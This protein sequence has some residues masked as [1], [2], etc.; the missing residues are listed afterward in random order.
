M[1]NIQQYIDLLKVE[2]EKASESL[3][4]F[5]KNNCNLFAAQRSGKVEAFSFA[6]AK[7]ELLLKSA[8]GSNHE[9][10]HLANTML[11]ECAASVE[12]ENIKEPAAGSSE[13]AIVRQNE[14]AKEVCPKCGGEGWIYLMN[15]GV[16]KC[17]KC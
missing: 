4:L 10:A 8:H 6:I 13:T 5:E 9:P 16:K 2:K 1:S 17:N 12:T 14:Q 7:A 11:D 15:G 3:Q